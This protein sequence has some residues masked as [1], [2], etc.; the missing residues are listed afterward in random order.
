MGCH[1]SCKWGRLQRRLQ[2]WR[3]L[4][5]GYGSCT[6]E[7]LYSGKRKPRRQKV[8]SAH[9]N[10]AR[11]PIAGGGFAAS[12]AMAV[13]GRARNARIRKLPAMTQSLAD[14][15]NDSEQQCQQQ[16]QQTTDERDRIL[17]DALLSAA[18]EEGEAQTQDQLIVGDAVSVCV[19]K[20][21]A[22]PLSHACSLGIGHA[23]TFCVCIP[24]VCDNGL[25]MFHWDRKDSYRQTRDFHREQVRHDTNSM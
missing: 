9:A 8:C 20:C 14:Y 15:E 2:V 17:Q 22:R 24:P 6:V 21:G 13:Q 1:V 4:E 3:W 7:Q 12:S 25:L 19:I 16:H 23:D 11:S 5:H 18:W 10:Y